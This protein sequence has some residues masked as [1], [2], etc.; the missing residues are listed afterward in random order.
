MVNQLDIE[1]TTV[2]R[3]TACDVHGAQSVHKSDQADW[4]VRVHA[5]K[6]DVK[7]RSIHDDEL[8]PNTASGQQS[9]NQCMPP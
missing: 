2:A 8:R 4:G 9:S 3:N 7:R 5:T 6:K 1:A